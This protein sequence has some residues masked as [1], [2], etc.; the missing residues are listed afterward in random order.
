MDHSMKE[1]QQPSMPPRSKIQRSKLG[2]VLTLI[3]FLGVVG[4]G[5]YYLFNTEAAAAAVNY[6]FA[7]FTGLSMLFLPCTLPL[8]FIIIPI[9]IKESF[10]KGL[11]MSLWFA[12]GLSVTLSIYGIALAAL[13]KALNLNEII[14]QVSVLSKIFFAIGGVI[15]LVWG[16]SELGLIKAKVVPSLGA[17]QP[18]FIQKQKNDYWKVFLLGLF[19]GNAGVSCPNPL[20]Y[21]LLADIV[22]VGNIFYGWMLMIVYS[23]GRVLPLILAVLLALFGFNVSNWLFKKA[24]LVKKITGWSLV[25]LG[26]A[27]FVIGVAHEWYERSIVHVVWNQWIK[28]IFGQKMAEISLEHEHAVGDWISSEYAGWVLLALVAIP[29]LWYYLKK[30]KEPEQMEKMEGH[31]HD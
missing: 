20:H 6:T 12:A 15:S 1:P 10:K 22:F 17:K 21:L 14:S 31:Q 24:V 2:L 27:I 11:L 19:L 18:D 9:A 23:V 26:A 8:V 7:L 28:G 5:F 3:A 30:R 4:F 25:F 13:G 16:L 29:V